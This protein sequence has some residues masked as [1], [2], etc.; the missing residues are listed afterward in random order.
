MVIDREAF[1]WFFITN[2]MDFRTLPGFEKGTAPTGSDDPDLQ[3]P[4]H[5]GGEED[6]ELDSEDCGA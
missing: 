1:I 4:Y 5:V 6:F 2:V 3:I